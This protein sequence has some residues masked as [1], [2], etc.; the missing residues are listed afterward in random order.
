M[1]QFRDYSLNIWPLEDIRDPKHKIKHGGSLST[2]LRHVSQDK[3]STTGGQG[4]SMF[5]AQGQTQILGSHDYCI[6]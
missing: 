2:V 6:E 1:P 4:L 5:S 3:L